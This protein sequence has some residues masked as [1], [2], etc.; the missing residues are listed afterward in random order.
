MFFKEL[1]ALCLTH[2]R[3]QILGDIF[4]EFFNPWAAWGDGL[5]IVLLKESDDVLAKFFKG[6]EGVVKQNF[7]A[8]VAI[9][10]S[11][12]EV[13]GA[14]CDFSLHFQIDKLKIN[15]CT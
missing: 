5:S 9:G 6:L 8:A 12:V 11:A 3:D 14:G 1:S 15:Y 2:A 10:V 7:Y 4:F 13:S